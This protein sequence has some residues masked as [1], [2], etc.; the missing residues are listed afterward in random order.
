MNE[1]Q[2]ASKIHSFYDRKT[3]EFPELNGS[4]NSL[5]SDVV[6][7]WGEEDDEEQ[8]ASIRGQV[9]YRRGFHFA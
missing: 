4:F 8:S 7:R 6:K 5:Y 9:Q 3:H 1:Q 2:V